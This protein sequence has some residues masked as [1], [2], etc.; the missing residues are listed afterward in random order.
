MNSIPILRQL[1]RAELL[2]RVRNG[3][4]AVLKGWRRR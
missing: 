4:T 3:V 1:A 2:R